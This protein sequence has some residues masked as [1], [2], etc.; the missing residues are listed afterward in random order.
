[1]M[2][3]SPNHRWCLQTLPPKL[4]VIW[5][6]FDLM[7][8]PQAQPKKKKSYLHLYFVKTNWGKTQFQFTWKEK[9]SF[10]PVPASQ[11]IFT[12]PRELFDLILAI[13]QFSSAIIT[14]PCTAPQR[15]GRR[16][17]KI[18]FHGKKILFTS[19]VSVYTSEKKRLRSAWW[20]SLENVTAFTTDTVKNKPWI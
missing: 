15:A 12:N 7:W 17:C 9:T 10:P 5:I 3:H 14:G 4:C 20:I 11:Y 2:I 19:Q 16:T 18:R 13:H 6:L 8:D 1:M